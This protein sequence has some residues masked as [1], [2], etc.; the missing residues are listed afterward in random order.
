MVSGIVAP[1]KSHFEDNLIMKHVI[2]YYLPALLNVELR[3]LHG[4]RKTRV[5]K[6]AFRK[7][8]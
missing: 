3:S 2:G 1:D 4:L 6:Q 7:K 8:L 5:V